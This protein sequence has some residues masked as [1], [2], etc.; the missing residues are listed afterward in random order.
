[1]KKLTINL[2][3]KKR[4]VKV[5]QIMIVKVISVFNL[6]ELRRPHYHGFKRFIN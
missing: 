2:T 6:D 5:S 3:Y 4:T 1:M